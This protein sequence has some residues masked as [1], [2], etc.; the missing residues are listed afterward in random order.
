VLV[1]RQP[2]ATSILFATD[3]SASARGAL[4]FLTAARYLGDRPI[5]VL[6]VGARRSAEAPMEVFFDPAPP[7]AHPDVVLDREHVEA[8]AASAV[9]HLRD[10]GHPASWT[11]SAGDPA[12]EIVEAAAGSAAT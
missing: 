2:A 5:C 12:H 4:E 1:V 11:I 8:H 7:A 9:E 6:S 10:A 3:G